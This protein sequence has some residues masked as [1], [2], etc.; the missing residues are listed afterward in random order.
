MMVMVMVSWSTE[1]QCVFFISTFTC[2]KKDR[3]KTA[4]KVW[5]N[6][7]KARQQRVSWLTL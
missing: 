7:G 5:L 1:E 3:Q 6:F 2:F 4:R